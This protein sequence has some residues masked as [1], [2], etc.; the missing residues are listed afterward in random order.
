MTTEPPVYEDWSG[1][2]LHVFARADDIRLAIS[3][4]PD[5]QHP[6]D[7]HGACVD[8]AF[9]DVRKV[10]AAMHEQAALPDRWSE[11]REHAASSLASFEGLPPVPGDD[12]TTIARACHVS[13]LRSFLAKMDEL[14]TRS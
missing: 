6:E 11:L 5:R 7:N 1:D 10:T 12:A 2:T 13:A 4:Y 9:A 3:Q 14:E 8:I